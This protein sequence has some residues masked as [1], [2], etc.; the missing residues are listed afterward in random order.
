MSAEFGESPRR[1]IAIDD[2]VDP[3][4]E[5]TPSPSKAKRS[6]GR[7]SKGVA[8][9]A[10]ASTLA[11][12]TLFA[13]A[14]TAREEHSPAMES[15]DA[16][17]AVPEAAQEAA[18]EGFAD[19]SDDISR[20]AL[21]QGLSEVAAGSN[22]R[23][24]ATVM[25]EAA[26]EALSSEAG[27]TAEERL[28]LM[29]ADLE[30]VEQQASKLKEEAEEAERRFEAASRM[31]AAGGMAEA[32]LSADDV[33]NLT[34]SGGSMPI[35]ENVRVGAGFGQTGSWSRYHTG[36]DFPA[37]TGTPVYAVASGVVL[38]PTDGGWAGTNIVVQHEPGA[39]LYA[40]LSGSLVSPGETVSPGQL[41]GYVGNTGRSFGS[42][43]HFEFYKNGTTPGD[44]YAASDPMPFLR[45]LGVS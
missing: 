25:D 3:I 19:R 5:I 37:P 34:A 45:S 13:Y 36:Q 30:L 12:G 31:A 26:D 10:L 40:H 33:S 43:L 7:F 15:V 21:R 16:G 24:R 23:E 18:A 41:I 14:F 6:R 20:D 4:E 27:H 2:G 8:A 39:T 42:H 11:V 35:K 9:A 44:V 28:Q 1:G 22:A 38:S 17:A 29:E 32:G